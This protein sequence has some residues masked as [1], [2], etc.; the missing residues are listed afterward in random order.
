MVGGPRC[1]AKCVFVSEGRNQPRLQATDLEH[2]N[3]AKQRVI[4]SGIPGRERL[5]PCV[6]LSGM[7]PQRVFG[8]GDGHPRRLGEG[9]GRSGSGIHGGEKALRGGAGEVLLDPSPA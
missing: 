4:A 3:G 9:W 2:A 5:N 8:S 1:K 6:W 7:A